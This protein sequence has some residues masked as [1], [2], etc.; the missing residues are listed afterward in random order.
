MCADNGIGLMRKRALEG[1]DRLLR[2]KKR[3]GADYGRV[4]VGVQVPDSDR[5]AFQTFLDELGYPWVDETDNPAYR[6]FLGNSQ[7]DKS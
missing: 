2:R 3:R 6:L 5:D 7:A 1:F 4:L